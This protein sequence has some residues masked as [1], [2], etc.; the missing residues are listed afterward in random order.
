[1]LIFMYNYKLTK[2]TNWTIFLAI[3]DKLTWSTCCKFRIRMWDWT[4][5]TKNPTLVQIFLVA[6]LTSRRQSQL[7]D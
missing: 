4:F 5:G 2:K 3:F 1:M 6:K 7:I